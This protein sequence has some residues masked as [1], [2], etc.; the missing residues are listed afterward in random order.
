MSPSPKSTVF[1]TFSVRRKQKIWFG[2]GC[3]ANGLWNILRTSPTMLVK[4][5]SN[6]F[7]LLKNLSPNL[8]PS[9]MS[10]FRLWDLKFSVIWRQYSSQSLNGHLPTTDSKRTQ[11]GVPALSSFPGRFPEKMG[12]AGNALLRYLYLTFYIGSHFSITD[13]KGV[14]D[15]RSWL[16]CFSRTPRV[17]PDL[18]HF[19]AHYHISGCAES[20]YSYAICHTLP[21]I[22]WLPLP[23]TLLKTLFSGDRKWS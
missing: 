1:L 20:V 9:R 12:E 6:V 16:Q 10:L 7:F 17:S 19:P 4:S 2:A 23:L 14:R 3:S 22:Q 5:R 13:T 21:F 15:T 11:E 18:T 8:S